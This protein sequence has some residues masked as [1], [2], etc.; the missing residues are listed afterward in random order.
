[1]RRIAMTDEKM[2]KAKSGSIH[3][4]QAKAPVLIIFSLAIINIIYPIQT[5]FY[6]FFL[7]LNDLSA[8]IHKYIDMGKLGNPIIRTNHN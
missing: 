5:P 6:S 4:R 3:T 2:A 7:L 1:M 8:N